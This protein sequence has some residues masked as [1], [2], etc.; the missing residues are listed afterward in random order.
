LRA[1]AGLDESARRSF[2]LVVAGMKGWHAQALDKELEPLLRGGEVRLAGYLSRDDLAAVMAGATALVYPSIYEGFGLPPL[3]AM[4][5]G[6]PAVAGNVASLP[7][8]VG[9]AGMLVEPRDAAQLRGAMLRM[10]EDP[11]ERMRLG[12]RAQ[13]RA[14]AFTWDRCAARTFAAYG[15]A[16]APTSR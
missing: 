12:A 9:D 16:V 6:V 10:I 11:Q 7:E 3:E 15:R 1:Y 4:A 14:A 8:V 5:C 13:V 2:P